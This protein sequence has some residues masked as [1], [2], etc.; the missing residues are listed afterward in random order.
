MRDVAPLISDDRRCLSASLVLAQRS[1]AIGYAPGDQQGW[2]GF[3]RHDITVVG[4]KVILI[5]VVSR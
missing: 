2:N 1:Q 5:Q 3:Q 4:A